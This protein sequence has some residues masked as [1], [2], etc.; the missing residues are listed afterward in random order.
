MSPHRL[1]SNHTMSCMGK[2]RRRKKKDGRSWRGLGKRKRR[3]QVLYSIGVAD[4]DNPRHQAALF[5]FKAL[6][7][8][9]PL[10]PAT[11]HLVDAR[12]TWSNLLLRNDRLGVALHLGSRNTGNI[13]RLFGCSRAGRKTV[14]LYISSVNSAFNFSNTMGSKLI[15]WWHKIIDMLAMIKWTSDSKLI[16]FLFGN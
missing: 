12:A 3:S 4:D 2:E 10:S 11:R 15:S 7:P 16:H 8:L 9:L 14:F 1:P 5:C 13:T 6:S